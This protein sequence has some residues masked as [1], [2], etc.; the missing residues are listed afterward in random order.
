MFFRSFSLN[1]NK[2]D[3]A[4][5][6]AIMTPFE[7]CINILKKVINFIGTENKLANEINY[8]IKTISNHQI[9][10][11]YEGIKKSKKNNNKEFN[12]VL[13][14]IS[15]YAEKENFTFQPHKKHS[16]TL[17]INSKN[18]REKKYSNIFD[19]KKI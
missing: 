19:L 10:Y 3:L 1:K 15:E 16:Q 11:S 5:Q 17:I 4:I 12:T 2:V 7:K 6:E 14:V 9:L 13:E 8:V 18:F